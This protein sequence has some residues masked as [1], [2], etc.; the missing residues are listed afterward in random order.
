MTIKTDASKFITGYQYRIPGQKPIEFGTNQIIH[1]KEFNPIDFYR[2]ASIVQAAALTIDAE[3]YAERY[4]TRFFENSAMPSVVLRTEQKLD[5]SLVDRMKAEW[6]N[7]YGGVEKSHKMA[8]L[9]GGL[10]VQPFSMNM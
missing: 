7:E 3:N 8:V 10:E 2:G 4:N 1:H 5:Q 6:Q 9:E